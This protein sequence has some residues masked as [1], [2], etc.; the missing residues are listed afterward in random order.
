V[1]AGGAAGRKRAC[2]ARDGWAGRGEM[3]VPRGAAMSCCARPLP[4]VPARRG[5]GFVATL[6]GQTAV[7][8]ARVCFLAARLDGGDTFEKED[9]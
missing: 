7:S 4:A 3:A 5:N 9:A 6:G 2:G 1:A 8:A